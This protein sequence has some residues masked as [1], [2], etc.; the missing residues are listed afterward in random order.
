MEKIQELYIK[1]NDSNENVRK[2]NNRVLDKVRAQIAEVE[3]QI[4]RL[5]H[6]LEINPEG[7]PQDLVQGLHSTRRHIYDTFQ[8]AKHYEEKIDDLEKEIA[9]KRKENIGFTSLKN[10]HTIVE[11][12]RLFVG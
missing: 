10:Q 3:A 7:V 9:K 8:E 11:L 1:Y 12:A 5:D 2:K 4:A 6:I